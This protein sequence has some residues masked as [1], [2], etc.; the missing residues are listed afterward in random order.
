MGISEIQC[1][2]TCG[3]LALGVPVVRLVFRDLSWGPLL[4]KPLSWL[5]QAT[6]NIQGCVLCAWWRQIDQHLSTY[7]YHC[8]AKHE[9][10]GSAYGA[11]AMC[12]RFPKRILDKKRAPVI[13]NTRFS[14]SRISMLSWME[15]QQR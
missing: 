9:V 13:G 6:R 12:I 5:L 14:F 2:R 8:G 3:Q 11:L 1:F 7:A 10:T 15:Y 4:W